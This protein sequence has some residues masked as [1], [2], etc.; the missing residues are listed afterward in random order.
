[1]NTRSFME[2]ALGPYVRL[3]PP[4]PNGPIHAWRPWLAWQRCLTDSS[5]R[6]SNLQR[7][8]PPGFRDSLAAELCSYGQYAVEAPEEL[9]PELRT[10]AWLAML[11]LLHA[12]DS[13][14]A[15]RRAAVAGLLLSLGFY[16][17]LARISEIPSED[18]IAA[19]PWEASVAL[20][21]ASACTVLGSIGRRPYTLVPLATI[22]ENAARDSDVRFNACI[23]L[24]VQHAKYTGDVEAATHWRECAWQS[25]QTL[26]SKYGA[27][28]FRAHLLT[29]RFYRSASYVPFMRR[30]RD[31]VVAE[32]A[33]CEA[34]A[35]AMTPR[36]ESEALLARENC[37]PMLQS[38]AKEAR[39]IGDL[40]LAK[41]RLERARDIDPMDSARWVELGEIHLDLGEPEPALTCYV[42]A[43][44]LAPPGGALAWFMAGEAARLAGDNETACTHYL[45]ALAIDGLC[46]A[47]LD[48]LSSIASEQESTR[49]LGALA[50]AVQHHQRHTAAAMA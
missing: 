37:M 40:A 46:V 14:A 49:H 3:A 2:Q 25:L 50:A 30:E 33:L 35:M 31:I 10:D 18:A 28:S 13:L 38:R 47:A 34:H 41:E 22:A 17:L 19:D 43:A 48:Q 44:R 36:S 29:S 45:H 1:M 15:P 9:S 20:T 27:E 12:F 26:T 23:D 24:I 4:S 21:T 42:T 8:L 32:M 6:Q 39:W 16:E 7:V 5:E 11:E